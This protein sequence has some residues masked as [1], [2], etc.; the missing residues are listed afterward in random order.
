[1][2][3]VSPPVVVLESG[4]LTGLAAPVSMKQNG[5]QSGK[6]LCQL[7]GVG[8]REAIARIRTM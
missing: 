8:L 6:R 7:S 1:M 3:L 4:R 5:T 2:P